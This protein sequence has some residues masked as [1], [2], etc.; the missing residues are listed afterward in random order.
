MAVTDEE[1]RNLIV[2]EIESWRRNKLLP[3]QYCDFLQNIYL[4]DLDD[5]PKGF[6]G[7]AVKKIEQ[8]SG[9]SWLLSFGIFA[10]ICFVVLHFS[11]FPF[12]LQISVACLVTS[13]FAVVGIRMKERNPTR[14]LLTLAA[15]MAFMIGVGFSIVWS[16][17]WS[18]S[19]GPLWLLG[20]CA[21]VWI[22][23]GLWLRLALPQWLGWIS[24]I[25]LY[26][27]LLAR[28]LPNAS[29]FEV[30]LFW[31]PASLLFC[32]LSWF[33]HVRN[34]S[35]GTAMFGAAI[36][37]W[38]MPEVYSAI[39]GIHPEWVQIEILIKI[40]IAGIGMFRLRKK[41]MEWVA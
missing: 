11:A 35:A 36:V 30:Q 18:G 2:K 5:R 41:W 34:Q 40:L 7:N 14:G 19:S 22:C 24:A 8:A 6:V 21:I 31:M 39:Y 25:A 29:L 23:G 17:G 26:A 12:L 27:L 38:F 3:E 33:L 28:H 10:L 37:L 13:A 9:K 4:E 20:I 1:K 15:G 16:N 32:W